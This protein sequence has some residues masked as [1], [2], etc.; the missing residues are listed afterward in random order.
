MANSDFIRLTKNRFL[1][2]VQADEEIISALGINEDEDAED[3]IGVRLFPYLFIP[4][5]QDIVKTYILIEVGMDNQRA[6]RYGDTT[7]RNIVYPTIRVTILAH[8]S[9]MLMHESGI[10]AVRTDYIAE[11]LDKKYN[12]KDGFGLKELEVILNEEYSLNNVYRYRRLVFRAADF[13]DG[14]CEE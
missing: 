1:S 4:P 6:Y 12:G 9:D 2:E 5:T 3:L 13:N 8:Q 10:S 7:V 14:Y 11:L